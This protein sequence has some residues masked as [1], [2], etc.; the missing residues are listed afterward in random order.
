VFAVTYLLVVGR[1][2]RH[3]FTLGWLLALVLCFVALSML[4]VTS[5]SRLSTSMADSPRLHIYQQLVWAVFDRPWTGYGWMQTAYAQSVAAEYVFGGVETDYAHNLILDFLVWFGIPMGILLL[6]TF[7]AVAIYNWRRSEIHYKMAYV[8]FAP[9]VVHSQLEFPFAY[10]F[11]LLP[12]GALLGYLG[13]HALA[14]TAQATNSTT[15]G[16]KIA[17]ASFALTGF[18][19]AAVSI[20]YLSLAEDFR[21]L[22][23]ENRNVGSVPDDFRQSSPLILTDMRFMMDMIRYKPRA[24]ENQRKIR[25]IRNYI[26]HA[27]NPSA[28]I[29]LISVEILDENLDA[30][31]TEIHRFRNLYNEKIVAWGIASLRS[32]YCEGDLSSR[33]S[34]QICCALTDSSQCTSE[35][36]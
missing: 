29:K 16:N 33:N 5:S 31:N 6:L 19:G 30:M 3:Y 1:A 24:A 27:H 13:G 25:K 22:R 9:L 15:I 8:M 20:D 18:L 4:G 32:A 7:F 10:A 34:Q 21:V 2:R 14:Q 36:R 35:V 12:A 17:I 11:F 28:Q 26:L 23:F